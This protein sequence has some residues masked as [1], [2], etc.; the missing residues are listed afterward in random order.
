MARSYKYAPELAREI[1]VRRQERAL[2]YEKLGILS[3]VDVA[4]AF[5]ICRG[6]FKTLNPS[7]MKICNALGIQPRTPGMVTRPIG[8]SVAEAM[9]SA[10]VL[11]AWDGTEEGAELLRRVLRALQPVR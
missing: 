7:V 8:R 1:S 11:T 4:Q 3:D 9:L 5:R 10:E 6:D 2:S